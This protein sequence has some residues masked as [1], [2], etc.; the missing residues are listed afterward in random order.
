MAEFHPLPTFTEYSSQ[1]NCLNLE[2]EKRA[3]ACVPAA[4][5][6]SL[7]H[8]SLKDYDR[9]Y[10]PNDDT[11]LLLDGIL[12]AFE[13]NMIDSKRK[14]YTTLEI[15][16]GTGVP[17]VYLAQKLQMLCN[18]SNDDIDQPPTSHVHHVTDINPYALEIAQATA[19]AN[20]IKAQILRHQCDL[21]T[22]LLQ[23]LDH[24]VDIILFNP[25]YVP[26]PED[27]V[28]SSGIEAS[29]AGGKNGRQVI[30]R[31]I[32]QLAKILA[33]PHGQAFIVTVDDNQ[34]EELAQHFATKG[35]IQKPWV[36]R[37]ARNEYLTIQRIT[38]GD[39]N[40]KKCEKI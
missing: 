29:W 7:D 24:A 17:T 15:G 3:K 33:K 6:P 27:E 28:G 21:V 16:C 31:A 25:P 37:R 18:D 9:V 35:L 23:D 5:M 4:V 11:Y 36:R 2:A 22:P 38:W 14:S 19:T 34:P 32:D 8:L 1:F 13:S 20:G 39:N 30:N 10:E 26:T 12:T 40:T